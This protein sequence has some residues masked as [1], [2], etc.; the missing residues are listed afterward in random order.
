MTGGSGLRLSPALL[1]THAGV[2]EL[3]TGR[4]LVVTARADMLFVRSLNDRSFRSSSSHRRNSCRPR[5][6]LASSSSSMGRETS[7]ICWSAARGRSEAAAQRRRAGAARV[8]TRAA[9][10]QMARV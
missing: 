9:A 3:P 1:A 10:R 6:Q 2:Y 8:I 7:P 4:E 5:L